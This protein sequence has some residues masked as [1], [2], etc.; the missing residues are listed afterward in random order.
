MINNLIKNHLFNICCLLCFN[1]FVFSQTPYLKQFTVDDGLPSSNVYTAFQDKDG[2]MWF[3]TD[4]G[5]TRF[6][7]YTFESFNMSSINASTD[8]WGI[9]EDSKNRLWFSSER[10]LSYYDKGEFKAIPFP[11]KYKTRK[12]IQQLL[13]KNGD[14]YIHFNNTK[15]YF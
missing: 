9:H 8:I 1:S 15:E 7:G 6:D 13:G 3:G 2:L 11:E 4:N 12:I 14:H 10:Q 5:I